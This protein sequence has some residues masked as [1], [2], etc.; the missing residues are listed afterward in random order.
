MYVIKSTILYAFFQCVKVKNMICL[1]IFVYIFN[2]SNH[3]RL[4]YFNCSVLRQIVHRI[5]VGSQFLLA[6]A[7]C[8]DILLT[9]GLR[10]KVQCS[11]SRQPV[12]WLTYRTMNKYVNH[13]TTRH[14]SRGW[15]T[16][17]WYNIQQ[18]Q[19]LVILVQNTQQLTNIRDITIVI[20]VCNNMTCYVVR[21]ATRCAANYKSL[22]EMQVY[23]NM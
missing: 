21:A 6:L 3:S 12:G 22:F 7:C 18:P 13:R 9:N 23:Y 5:V 20:I 4:H 2:N 11:T 19:L 15:F 16:V 10:Y 1:S 14:F 17:G 8:A